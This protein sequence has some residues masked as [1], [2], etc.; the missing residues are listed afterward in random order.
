TGQPWNRVENKN[1][2]LQSVTTFLG[3]EN[4]TGELGLYDSSNDQFRHYARPRNGQFVRPSIVMRPPGN[5]QT[6]IFVDGAGRA[7]IEVPAGAAGDY[8]IRTPA[9]SESEGYGAVLRA[10]WDLEALGRDHTVTTAL[11]FRHQEGGLGFTY[12]GSRRS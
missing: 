1:L 4:M 5:T 3:V 7:Y 11:E 8:D 10:T 2:S 9:E 6:P 12:S